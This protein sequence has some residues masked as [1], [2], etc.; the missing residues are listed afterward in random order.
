MPYREQLAHSRFIWDY[1][2]AHP[3]RDMEALKRAAEVI[4]LF[5]AGYT[6]IE[7]PLWWAPALN[8]ERKNAYGLKYR[9]IVHN[10]GMEIERCYRLGVCYDLAWDL[11]GLDLS[12]YREI[13]R[14]KEDGTI[15]VTSGGK[16]Q[17]FSEPRPIERPEGDPPQLAVTLSASE[18]A[19]P[20]WV[21]ATAEVKEGSAP[22]YY[23]PSR[24]ETG[25]W[26]NQKVIWQLYGPE[27]WDYRDFEGNREPTFPALTLRLDKP[28]TYRLRASVVDQAGRLAVVWKEIAV[29][30]PPPQ[31]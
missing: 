20:L 6:F 21:T 12:G 10:L 16:T 18:G 4:I 29:H 2:K 15:E 22:V 25:A 31:Q 8:L 14:V 3:D 11:E 9:D 28:G 26:L 24:D 19:A 7:E 1:A 27:E 23:T 30:A 17:T 13:V 5:P